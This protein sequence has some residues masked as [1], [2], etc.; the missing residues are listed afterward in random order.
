MFQST[1]PFC[2]CVHPT[3]TPSVIVID[4]NIKTCLIIA[5]VVS[6]IDDVNHIFSQKIH[7]SILAGRCVHASSCGSGKLVYMLQEQ[8]VLIVIVDEC[9]S[10]FGHYDQKH[11][12]NVA[13]SSHIGLPCPPW[14]RPYEQCGR[15]FFCVGVLGHN[16]LPLARILICVKLQNGYVE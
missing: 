9:S 2:V 1:Q 14:M 4:S 10:W 6:S 11:S 13:V 7:C 5:R 3:Q 16:R 12:V 8:V 15:Y